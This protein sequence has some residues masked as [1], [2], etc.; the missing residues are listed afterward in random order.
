MNVASLEAPVPM[1]LATLRGEE[2]LAGRPVSPRWRLSLAIAL[3]LAILMHLGL[4][5]LGIYLARHQSRPPMTTAIPITLVAQPP[6]A[7]KAIEPPKPAPKPRPPEPKPPEPKP[8]PAVPV[9]PPPPE[10][11]P[12]FRQSG[13]NERTT[14][15]HPKELPPSQAAPA[16]A[17][18]P[19][20]TPEKP[21]STEKTPAPGKPAPPKPAKAQA[22]ATP[23][24]P[25]A[26]P[27]E[28]A[29]GPNGFSV[30]PAKVGP[31]AQAKA[32][33]EP[34]PRKPG[35]LSFVTPD[36]PGM[37]LD[38]APTSAVTFDS[39]EMSGD[40]YLNM[41]RDRVAKYLPNQGEDSV[42]LTG[43]AIYLVALN[44]NGQLAFVQL[45]KSSGMDRIDQLG[46]TAIRRA[47]PMPPV[48]RDF[49][50]DPV[51]LTASL[52]IGSF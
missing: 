21:P 11:P 34:A 16:P 32:Q 33:P 42:G 23:K 18:I 27:P 19:G 37:G 26:P 38:S 40:P 41:L 17:P 50:G 51:R 1:V 30:P 24:P 2:P 7:P 48:P 45:L 12:E 46:E 28:A 25:K 20:P 9:P 4:V 31:T 29:L 36:A 13:P 8:P 3:L 10:T 22:E 39:S 6:P 44:R 35:Q 43:R 49:P 47:A 15:A 52:V 14:T 5:W